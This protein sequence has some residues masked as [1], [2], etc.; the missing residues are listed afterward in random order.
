MTPFV[1]VPIEDKI[2]PD[3]LID[4]RDMSPMT[5]DVLRVDLPTPD[6]IEQLALDMVMRQHDPLGVL[7]EYNISTSDFAVISRLPLYTAA[8]KQMRDAINTDP[9]YRTRVLARRALE[10]AIPTL[11][12]MTNSPL[13]DIKERQN[14]IKLLQS[15]ASAGE[16]TGTQARKA[17]TGV[18]IGINFGQAV[19]R[20]LEQ[21]I[22]VETDQ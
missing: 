22:R 17:G 6:I 19:G 14:A 4:E 3:G 16:T 2:E 13:A 20:Q 7:R 1:M 18:T 21:V 5:R 9:N 11:V 12:N 8:H 10:H 15:L